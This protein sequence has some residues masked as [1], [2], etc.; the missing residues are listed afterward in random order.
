MFEFKLL[1]IPVR[2]E[3]WFWITLAFISG[4]WNIQSPEQIL[5]LVLFMLAGFFSILIHE[6]GH[7]LMIKKYGHF[8][9]VVLSN[10]GGYA[11]MP[12]GVLSRKQSFLVTAAGPAIQVLAGAIMLLVIFPLLPSAALIKN[13]GYYFF[14]VSFFW[15][16]INCIPIYPLDGGQMLAA[17]M[18]PKRSKTVHL[19]G[20]LLA[21]GVGIWALTSGSFL[22][23]A[24]MGMFAYQNYQLY[25]QYR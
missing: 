1:G 4:K 5:D 12:R 7:A 20:M 2:V 14:F 22:L 9:Q 6:F 24:F 11:T 10:F 13:F 21:G 25:S 17:I 16:A 8:T 18:G 19:I 3:L 15:A 23:T